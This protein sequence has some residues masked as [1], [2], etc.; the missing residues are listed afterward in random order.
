MV[1]CREKFMWPLEVYAPVSQAKPSSVAEVKMLLKWIIINLTC[2]LFYFK[3]EKQ[4]QYNI[5]KQKSDFPGTFLKGERE[6][7]HVVYCL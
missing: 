1:G 6:A 4:N 5:K 7:A 2:V 3:K